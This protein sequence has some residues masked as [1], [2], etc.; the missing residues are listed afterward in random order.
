MAG[1]N[2]LHGHPA[3]SGARWHNAL[4]IKVLCSI[5]NN[6]RQG[7]SFLR[8]CNAFWLNGVAKLKTLLYKVAVGTP[9]PG[10][11]NQEE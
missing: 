2:K 8:S 4:V 1:G 5:E 3:L 11:P 10:G 6:F 7:R 9:I